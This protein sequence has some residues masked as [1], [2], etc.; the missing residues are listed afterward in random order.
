M[1]KLLSTLAVAVLLASCGSKKKV[2]QRIPVP[3]LPIITTSNK[4]INK[5]IEKL[6]KKSDKLDRKTIAY[7]SNYAE[8]A[9]DEMKRYHIP[10]SIT[11]AQGILESG[12]GLSQL[13]LKSNNHFGVK[14]H[15]GWKGDFVR[16]DDD[17][18]QECFR[19]YEKVSSSY[20]DH[21]KFLVSR[22]RYSFLFDYKKTDYKAWAKGLKKAGYATDKKYP[23][24]LIKLIENYD[25]DHFDKIDPVKKS[26]KKESD[27]I[28]KPIVKIKKVNKERPKKNT[29]KVSKGDTLYSISKKYKTTV[30]QIKKWNK[31]RSNTIS[32][33]QVLIVN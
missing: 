10:A 11:L 22:S 15:K 6:K 8:Q 21:S 24:K 32:I 27:V 31:L 13:A 17:K 9:I 5:E 28:E 20:R 1:N 14:C 23:D 30:E 33:D 29:H 3:V 25:L 2:T 12:N 19:K 7:I 26:A 16:H 4:D 18:A